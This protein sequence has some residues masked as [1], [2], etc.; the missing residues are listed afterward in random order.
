[1]TLLRR[2]LAAGPGAVR[3]RCQ[4]GLQHCAMLIL[5]TA[6]GDTGTRGLATKSPRVHRRPRV[7]SEHGSSGS[8]SS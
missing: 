2:T 6:P 3:R 7:D 5:T 1:M 4:G 8:E